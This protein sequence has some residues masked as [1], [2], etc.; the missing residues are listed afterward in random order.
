MHILNNTFLIWGLFDLPWWLILMVRY[1]F[2]CTILCRWLACSKWNNPLLPWVNVPDEWSE[3]AFVS[4]AKDPGSDQISA[5]FPY[6]RAPAF[7]LLFYTIIIFAFDSF[8]NVCFVNCWNIFPF[9]LEEFVKKTSFWFR[10]RSGSFFIII[11][12]QSS[13]LCSFGVWQRKKN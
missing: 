3:S 10:F 13:F 8:A 5:S 7:R 9:W 4:K 6:I 1:T 11:I 12:A 2:P